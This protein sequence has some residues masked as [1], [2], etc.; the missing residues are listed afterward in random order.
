VRILSLQGELQ[1]RV[2][3]VSG[4]VSFRCQ[5]SAT[6]LAALIAWP[7]GRPFLPGLSPTRTRPLPAGASIPTEGRVLGETNMPGKQRTVAV[8][9]KHAVR[10]LYSLGPN[11]VG[12]T[13]LL[14]NLMAQDMENGHGVIVIETKGTADLFYGALDIIPDK[15]IHDVIVIDID[16]N[17]M[18]VGFNILDQINTGQSISELSRIIGELYAESAR[19][20]L[21]PQVMHYMLHA[22]AAVP[23]H[24]FIDLPALLKPEGGRQES[25]QKWLAGQMKDKDVRA[26][27]DRYIGMTETKR[28]QLADPVYNRTWEFTS[29]PQIR[30]ILGQR[31]SS[32]KMVDALQQNKIVLIKLSGGGVD[33]RSAMLAGTLFTN[34]VWDAAK[35]ANAQTANFLYLDEFQDIARFP[36]TLESMLAQARSANLGTVLAHQSTS[37]IRAELRAAVMAN[38]LTKVIFQ[39]SSD[40]ARALAREFGRHITDQDFLNLPARHAIVTVSTDAGVSAPATIK[41]CPPPANTKN[42]EKVF[43][44]SSQY[45]RPLEDVEARLDRPPSGQAPERERNEQTKTGRWEGGPI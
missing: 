12:K 10:H 33:D 9:Y 23:G 43:E 3:D 29:R 42:R 31:E 17:E 14:L 45:G 35:R 24:T 38:A 44:L 22:L 32:F 5:L 36:I 1:R 40:D 2:Q 15:R 18:P 25:W 30:R 6:E 20:L 21:A 4:S 27:L 8:S 13:T 28:N 19:S 41:T 39:T 26:Y 34:A 7:V 11:G 16:E 37:Q